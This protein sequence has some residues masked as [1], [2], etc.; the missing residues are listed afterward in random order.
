MRRM[1]WEFGI[2]CAHI[3][4]KAGM[5]V[6]WC[7][8]GKI[9]Q[10]Q[11]HFLILSLVNSI[12]L[13]LLTFS[14]SHL[15]S[16]QSSIC[17]SSIDYLLPALKWAIYICCN[18]ISYIKAYDWACISKGVQLKSFSRNSA[19]NL[20]HASGCLLFIGSGGCMYYYTVS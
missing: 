18:Y 16:F 14:R 15:L 4:F 3:A 12:I 5:H 19:V 13:R 9:T 6:G 17:S 20:C 8:L 10:K 7:N 2:L 11:V 1:K